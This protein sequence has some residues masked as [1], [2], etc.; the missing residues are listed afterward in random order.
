ME[1]TR[2]THSCRWSTP[3]L[4]LQWPYWLDAST[5]PWSC[6]PDGRLQLL[7]SSDVCTGCPKWVQRGPEDK[8]VEFDT[9]V[10]IVKI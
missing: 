1:F 9:G 4:F 5:W 8:P 3:T 10:P 6:A 7:S 2:Q